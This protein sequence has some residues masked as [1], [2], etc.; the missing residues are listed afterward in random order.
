MKW[1]CCKRFLMILGLFRSISVTLVLLFPPSNLLW[2]WI[3][4][5]IIEPQLLSC[6]SRCCCTQCVSMFSKDNR[7]FPFLPFSL[8]C[9][10]FFFF[11]HQLFFSFLSPPPDLKWSNPV[12][13][14][15]D[16]RLERLGDGHHPCRRRWKQR[17]LGRLQRL[18]WCD[19]PKRTWEREREHIAR[20]WGLSI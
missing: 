2:K 13:R 19:I 6:C 8:V 15:A 14:P 18:L 5:L 3:I 12:L 10:L 7:F 11:F 17:L 4:P 16:S 1:T 20:R 9:F